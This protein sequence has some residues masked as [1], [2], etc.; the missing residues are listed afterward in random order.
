[1]LSDKEIVGM[2]RRLAYKY[3]SETHR[4]DMLQE[5]ILVCYELLA[6]NPKTHP[7][8]LYRE[9]NRRMHD[10]LNLDTQPV[11][12]PA[13]NISRRMVRDIDNEV[14]G[15]MT[16]ASAAWLKL[17]IEAEDRP[18]DEDYSVS[19]KDHALDF[20]TKEYE[21]YLNSVALKTLSPTELHV[22]KMRYYDGLTQDEVGE[23]LETNQKW[24]SRHEMT[25]LSKLKE[26]LL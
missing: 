7:A 26:A 15:T 2:C 18:Y 8:K 24:V 14:F 12:I 17:V 20:E 21:A 9:A 25:A 11:A 19:D 1:M 23:A 6:Q 22:V 16:D 13:H 5:G 10:Y 4:E 3:N